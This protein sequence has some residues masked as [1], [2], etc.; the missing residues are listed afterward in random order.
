VHEFS[1]YE[2]MQIIAVAVDPPVTK[3]EARRSVDATARVDYEV[4][5]FE[6]LQLLANL[7]AFARDT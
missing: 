5:A 6:Q 7:N 2:E 3:D 4:R 1:L